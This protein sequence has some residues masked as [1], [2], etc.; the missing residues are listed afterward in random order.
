MGRFGLI[1]E[2]ILIDYCEHILRIENNQ[3]TR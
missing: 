3:V 1:D 2:K